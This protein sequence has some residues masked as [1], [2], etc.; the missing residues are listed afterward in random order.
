M[1]FS[2]SPIPASGAHIS[3]VSANPCSNTTA[4]PWPATRTYSSVPLVDTIW[5]RNVGGNG[6]MPAT[7]GVA[8]TTVI[9][10]VIRYLNI[11]PP[12]GDKCTLVRSLPA[13]AA[14]VA[15]LPAI[16]LPPQ[17]KDWR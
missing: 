7:T 3:P 9:A 15:Q 4:G 8:I 6:L 12:R 13:A 14:H 16:V 17:E 2:Q 1:I 11:A 10:A 5:V